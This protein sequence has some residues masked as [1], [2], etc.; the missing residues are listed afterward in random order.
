VLG[1]ELHP[2]A[3]GRS[4]RRLD[5]WIATA[6]WVQAA[7]LLLVTAAYEFVSW[8][9]QDVACVQG[10]ADCITDRTWFGPLDALWIGLVATAAVAAIVA[11]RRHRRGAALSALAAPWLAAAIVLAA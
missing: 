9:L 5:D 1:A 11:A 6:A 8:T 10:E 4:P 2:V 3:R 7:L